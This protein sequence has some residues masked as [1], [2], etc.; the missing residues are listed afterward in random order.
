M[1]DNTGNILGRTI[2]PP[3]AW[4]AWRPVRLWH[5]EI[6][7]FRTVTRRRCGR[8][9]YFGGPPASYWLYFDR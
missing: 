2:G 1:N 4:F 6:A 5:G 8:A 7:W 3:E 9:S